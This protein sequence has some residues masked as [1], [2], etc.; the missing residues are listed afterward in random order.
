MSIVDRK[1][2]HPYSIYCCEN[3]R[4][5]NRTRSIKRDEKR[6]KNVKVGTVSNKQVLNLRT[7]S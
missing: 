4:V 6:K 3:E 7:C 2:V 5:K 1:I